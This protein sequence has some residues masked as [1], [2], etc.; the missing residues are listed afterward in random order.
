MTFSLQVNNL[1][2]HPQQ[3]IQSGVVTSPYFGRLTGSGPRTISL[4]LQF[5]NLF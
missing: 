1:L 4:S 3:N 5:Q 2:N